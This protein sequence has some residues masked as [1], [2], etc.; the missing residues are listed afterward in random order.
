MANALETIE[1]QDNTHLL[2]NKLSQPVEE[3]FDL[4][5]PWTKARVEE[6]LKS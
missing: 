4:S 3:I 6:L 5:K 1:H 2:I